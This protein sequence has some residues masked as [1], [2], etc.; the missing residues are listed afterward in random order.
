MYL[1]G[2]R[3]LTADIPSERKS[4]C[5]SQQSHYDAYVYICVCMLEIALAL[6]AFTSLEEG[7]VRALAQMSLLSEEKQ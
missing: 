5:I 7:A 6:I 2:R 4:I 3:G 1:W